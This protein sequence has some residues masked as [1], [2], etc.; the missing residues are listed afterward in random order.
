M[1]ETATQDITILFYFIEYS[2][3]QKGLITGLLSLK[4]V[5]YQN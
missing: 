3:P 4:E 1:S 2:V 5:K